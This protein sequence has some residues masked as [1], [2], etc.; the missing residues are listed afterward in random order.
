M[1]D[2]GNM[3]RKAFYAFPQREVWSETLECDCL[4]L[5]PQGIALH[6]SGY[7]YMDAVA[8]DY[9]NERCVRVSGCSDVFMLNTP[10]DIWTKDRTPL[11]R[12]VNWGIDCLKRSGLLRVFLFDHRM[13]I[14]GAL[15]TLSVYPITRPV[16]TSVTL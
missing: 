11:P 15:S 10:S 3:S 14:P 1:D 8:V 5:L 13:H 12:G 7:R 4:V 6:D 9:K 16:E 2:L